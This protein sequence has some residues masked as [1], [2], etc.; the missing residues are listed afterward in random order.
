MDAGIAWPAP[1]ICTGDCRPDPF[2]SSRHPRPR[3]WANRSLLPRKHRVTSLGRN[4]WT[5]IVAVVA[6]RVVKV[7]G[8]MIIQVVAVRHRLV[9]AAGAV[10]MPRLMPATASSSTA[11]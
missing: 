6:V 4:Q 8:D 11:A 5:V 9:R 1:G 3:Q 10:H 7:A 2:A